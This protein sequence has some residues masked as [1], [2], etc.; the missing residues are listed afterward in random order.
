MTEKKPVLAYKEQLRLFSEQGKVEFLVQELKALQK[1][2]RYLPVYEP[3]IKELK[4]L[5]ETAKERKKDLEHHKQRIQQSIQEDQEERE[6]RGRQQQEEELLEELV[7][8]RTEYLSTIP[9]LLT[10][11]DATRKDRED[12]LLSDENSKLVIGHAVE[13]YNNDNPQQ[14]ID[15]DAI[16]HE[17]VLRVDEALK[18]IVERSPQAF[19]LSSVMTVQEI[20]KQIKTVSI[21]HE[22]VMMQAFHP[23]PTPSS[24][25]RPFEDLVNNLATQ[26]FHDRYMDEMSRNSAVPLPKP[27]P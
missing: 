25:M 27:F 15:A 1:E 22:D 19:P 14:P 9:R 6:R 21:E 10:L 5:I 12:G 17:L 23:K 7:A 18:A 20:L 2:R 24:A 11:L 4:Q 26:L 13:Q 16:A 3:L 8:A